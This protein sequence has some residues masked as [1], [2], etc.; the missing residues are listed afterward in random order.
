MSIRS[1][2]GDSGFTDLAFS[3][4][5]SKDC[6]DLQVIGDLDELISF[7]G[8]VKVRLRTK[9]DKNIINRIQTGLSTITSEIAVGMERK[10]DLGILLARED[11]DWIE[12]KVYELEDR[13]K[14]DHY[15]YIPGRN[16]ISSLLDIAR[17]VAR[18]AERSVVKFWNEKELRNEN[19][20][21][22]M[23]CLSD[24]LFIMARESSGPKSIKKIRKKLRKKG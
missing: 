3:K 17:S 23:N 6:L 13:T 7:L 10:K 21:I 4:K 2:K 9:K 19:I 14:C 15:F 24:A 22:F 16:E 1:G 18:R 11:A 5:V 20:L 12:K 8:L